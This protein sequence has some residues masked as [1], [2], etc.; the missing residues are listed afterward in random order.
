MAARPPIW[1]MRSQLLPMAEPLVMALAAPAAPLEALVALQQQHAPHVGGCDYVRWAPRP[2][3][4]WRCSRCGATHT[5]LPVRSFLWRVAQVAQP[6]LHATANTHQRTPRHNAVEYSLPSSTARAT[7]GLPAR[8]LATASDD[9]LSLMLDKEHA[10]M[11]DAERVQS[12]ASAQSFTSAPPFPPR[13][14]KLA[15]RG[16][17]AL[18]AE[19][20]PDECPSGTGG[21]NCH[22]RRRRLSQDCDDEHN[23]GEHQPVVTTRS[24]PSQSKKLP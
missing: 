15:E 1:E 7:P 8:A 13:L 17:A 24:P 5:L 4:S 20:E 14:S 18:N 9:E 2:L 22:G 21:G 11:E 16:V 6:V 19:D 3:F 10:A 12:A 23:V